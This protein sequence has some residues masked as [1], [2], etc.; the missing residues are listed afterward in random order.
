MLSGETVQLEYKLARIYSIAATVKAAEFRALKGGDRPYLGN[1]P[2]S[3]MPFDRPR[4]RAEGP[5]NYRWEDRPPAQVARRYRVKAIQHYREV[6]KLDPSHVPAQLGLAWCLDQQGDREEA[7]V[8][9]RKALQLAWAREGKAESIHEDSFVQETS[10]YLLA[11]LDP[12]KDAKEIKQIEGYTQAILRKG[13]SMTPVVIPLVAGGAL[14]QLVDSQASVPFDLDGSGLPR[15]WGWI[16]P[17]AA[18]LVF[19]PNRTGRITSGLQLIGARTFWVFWS[20]GY[21]VLASL[22]DNGDGWLMEEELSGLALWRDANG[23]AVSE[24]GE[25]RPIQEHGITA[26]SRIHA[27]GFRGEVGIGPRFLSFLRRLDSICT[28]TERCENPTAGRECRQL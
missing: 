11:L 1:G 28:L 5:V 8:A 19:D 25:V 4:F 21:E 23:N 9:Y 7:K 27:V 22:D 13:R 18:W 17:S 20:T 24:P 26:L 6:L 14:E 16:R 10:G 3:E 2:S 15:S 12:K